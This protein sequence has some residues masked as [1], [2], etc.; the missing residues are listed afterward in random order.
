MLS[1]LVTIGLAHGAAPTLALP[2][3]E[4]V[5]EWE[6][7]LDAAGLKPG[8][9]GVRVETGA[10]WRLRYAAPGGER[11]ATVVAPKTE[12]GREQV[13]ILAASLMRG[14]SGTR[15]AG[16]PPPTSTPLPAAVPS[17]APKPPVVR[18]PPT[19]RAVVPVAAVV[20][21]VP[22]PPP[23]LVA[24]TPPAPVAPIAAPIPVEA[25][26]PIEP[27]V[28][29]VAATAGPV[30]PP[31]PTPVH[32]SAAAGGIGFVRPGLG[33][34]PGG[35]LSVRAARGPLWLEL[36]GAT[37]APTVFETG[38]LGLSTLALRAGGRANI[39]EHWSLLGGIG[40]AAQR[41][42]VVDLDGTRAAAGAGVDLLLGVDRR[43]WRS[44]AVEVNALGS[45]DAQDLRIDAMAVAP[46]RFSG[47]LALGLRV[48][49]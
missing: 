30:V 47:G 24:A 12:E 27:V 16:T 22:P 18:P 44:L 29:V 9:G 5:A 23:E 39:G 3:G 26:A 8:V 13:A 48:G 15:A 37:Y 42:S 14:G 2:P 20:A 17:P 31:R 21:S 33:P 10:V 46:S 1:L 25:P 7:A 41:W 32:L 45:W 6:Q 28:A 40:V 4:V 34:L 19:F 36:V 49:P 11:T 38:S 43:L 35:A